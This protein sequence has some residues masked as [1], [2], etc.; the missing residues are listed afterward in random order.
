M[1]AHLVLTGI[2]ALTIGLMAEPPRCKTVDSNGTTIDACERRDAN[3]KTLFATQLKD[4][5]DKWNDC[6]MPALIYK[7]HFV[8]AN[9]VFFVTSVSVT[10]SYLDSE[11]VDITVFIEQPDHTVRPY[12]RKD[13]PVI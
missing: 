4:P 3:C 8:A 12:E 10:S 11:R 5:S 1:K 2:C 7:R 6:I 9:M 13:V